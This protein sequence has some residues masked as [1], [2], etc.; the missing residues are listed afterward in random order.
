M[1]TVECRF[2]GGP[3]PVCATTDRCRGCGMERT[4]CTHRPEPKGKRPCPLREC[5]SR[6]VRWIDGF[7]RLK[8][9]TCGYVFKMAKDGVIN[10]N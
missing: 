8:C 10:E 1:K 7:T 5:G 9:D 2:C 4:E 6:L 3:R